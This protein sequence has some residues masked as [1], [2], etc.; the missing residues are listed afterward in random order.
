[1]SE[2]EIDGRTYRY[3]HCNSEVL[4]APG[5]CVYCDHFPER[6]M[7]REAGGTPFTP[8]ESNGWSGNTAAPAGKPHTHMGSTGI[9]TAVPPLPVT[10]RGNYVPTEFMA[11]H[12][13]RRA[14]DKLLDRFR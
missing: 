5:R 1:M 10:N 3:P 7:M 11:T 8:D 2:G 14:I 6:Q 12:P 4:H 9:P 13:R